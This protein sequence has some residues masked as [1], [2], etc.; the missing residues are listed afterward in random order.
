[1]D[2]SNTQAPKICSNQI[3]LLAGYSLIY[4]PV[5]HYLLTA[6]HFLSTA[7]KSALPHLN[8]P[9]ICLCLS[10]HLRTMHQ[11]TTQMGTGEKKKV[12]ELLLLVI[13]LP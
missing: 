7:G 10:F 13:A 6:D 9:S 2:T 8:E 12:G 3:H 1:M 11:N 4:L 5:K